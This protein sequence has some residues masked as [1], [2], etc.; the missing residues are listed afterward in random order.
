VR[1]A[2]PVFAVLLLGA[3]G[4]GRAESRRDAGG[5]PPIAR[6]VRVAR[7]HDVMKMDGELK[8][9]S[10]N[11]IAGRT[12]AF[13]DGSGGEA[14]P[15]SEARFMWDADNLYA[16]L[17]AADNDI[18]AQVT[19]HDGPVWIDDSFALHLTPDQDG[20]PTYAF[21]ISAS[22]VVTDAK[23]AGVAMGAP[24]P[25]PGRQPDDVSWESGITLGVDHD[26]TVN[27]SN[28]ED[29]EW[30][31]EAAIPLR[32]MGVEPRP[33]T[34]IRVEISRCDTPRKTTQKRCGSTG[35]A[36]QPRVLELAP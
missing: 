28:D 6:V 24:P 20:A 27:N 18:R 4:C 26:G 17:Y 21:D 2:L 30:V 11:A 29:E 32:S 25:N 31:I 5:A 13:V 34:R 36:K 14:R 15:Y 33:G 3:T 1:S 12:G 23:R 7:T 22:G 35:G 16:G 19:A 10:W 9:R 8:E